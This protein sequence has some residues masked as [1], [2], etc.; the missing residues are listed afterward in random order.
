VTS[1][2]EPNH[3]EQVDIERELTRVAVRDA[4]GLCGVPRE[5]AGFQ[6][7]LSAGELAIGPGRMYADGVLIENAERV[8]AS[9]QPFGDSLVSPTDSDDGATGGSL[10]YVEVREEE[11]S[12][13]DDERLR[14]KALGGPDTMTRTQTQWR[15][16]VAPLADL[17]VS[18][19][20]ILAAVAERTAPDIAAWA[21]TTGRLRAAA[22]VAS[23]DAEGR[24][25]LIPPTAGFSAQENLLYRVEIHASGDLASARYKWS[26][27]NGAIQGML[28]EADGVRTLVGIEANEQIGTGNWVEV[29]TAEQRRAGEAGPLTQVTINPD[30][31]VALDPDLGDVD[32]T[33]VTLWDHPAD[34]DAAGIA[35]HGARMARTRCAPTGA[36]PSAA[37]WH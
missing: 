27:R 33:I 15:I 32:G 36:D 5:N 35:L 1:V 30:R 23:V 21:P 2:A 20:E 6:I 7:G 31:S 16:G 3:N 8:L 29:Q 9:E 28:R 19:D 4:I 18:A 25:C 13:L 14:E 12:A 34:A 10:V 37:H 24:P 26:R 22:S 11:V 17:G